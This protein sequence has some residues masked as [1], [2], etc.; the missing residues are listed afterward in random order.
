MIACRLA[1]TLRVEMIADGLATA[2]PRFRRRSHVRRLMFS[3][4]HGFLRDRGLFSYSSRDW[5]PLARRRISC[6]MRF[7][8]PL[9]A[10]GGGG[11]KVLDAADSAVL[12]RDP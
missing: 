9:R 2:C 7:C 5:A 1:S 10:G 3:A 6:V 12:V 4:F 8:S 11:P